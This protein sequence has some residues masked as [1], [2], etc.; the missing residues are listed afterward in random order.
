MRVLWTGIGRGRSCSANRRPPEIVNPLLQPI[1]RKDSLPDEKHD[2]HDEENEPD[3]AT[4]DAFIEDRITG[5]D[6]QSH[7]GR[8]D[9][10]TVNASSW[11]FML[12]GRVLALDGSRDAG[13]AGA[14]QRMVRRIGE[15]LIQA[16][17]RRGPCSAHMRA[18][19]VLRR[20]TNSVC[21]STPPKLA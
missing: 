10:L 17:L 4:A 9:S 13:V 2:H 12:T 21:S 14:I 11:A 8:A 5:V 19:E 7:L 18:V 3:A 16:A 15:P 1:C 20:T 6:W